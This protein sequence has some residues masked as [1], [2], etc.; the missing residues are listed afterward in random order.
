MQHNEHLRR[1]SAADDL[2]QVT[3]I[4]AR[5][6]N[7]YSLLLAL[8]ASCVAL[9]SGGR[10][11]GASS[12]AQLARAELAASGA[13]GARSRPFAA[14]RLPLRTALEMLDDDDEA[15]HKRDLSRT[16]LARPPA[17]QPYRQ[18]ARRL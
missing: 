14:V 10:S 5:T 12:T 17:S 9:A 15:T 7:E 8:A 4:A 18:A 3:S 13:A 16:S 2:L 11:S 6:L 1:T